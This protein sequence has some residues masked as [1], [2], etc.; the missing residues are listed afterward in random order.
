M[1]TLILFASISIA[2]GLLLVNVYTSLV[3]AK[4]WGSD[5]PHSITTA[6][7]YFKTVSPGNFF[8]IFSP[9]NQILG[10]LVLILF[11]KTS[12]SIRLCLGSALILYILGDVFTFAYFYPRNDIMFKTAQLTDIDLLRK[13]VSEWSIMNWVRSLAVLAGLIFSFISL[14]KIYLLQSK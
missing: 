5:I 8:R 3:D 9:V 14:H 12:P 7:E 11:W 10:L 6:R 13:T 2:S 1:K 4:S